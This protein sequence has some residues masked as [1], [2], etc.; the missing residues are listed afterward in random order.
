MS[1]TI[2][3]CFNKKILAANA[4]ILNPYGVDN[5]YDLVNQGKWTLP[6]MIQMSKAVTSDG[7]EDTKTYGFAAHIGAMDAFWKGSDLK[8]LEISNKGD[9]KIAEDQNS[10]RANSLVATL[11]EF[12]RSSAAK[13]TMAYYD[14]SYVFANA[15]NQANPKCVT[16]N[17]GRS[18]FQMSPIVSITDFGFAELAFEFGMLPVPKYDGS[19]LMYKT[20]PGFEYSVCCIPRVA[21][22][23]EDLCTVLECLAI[24]GYNLTS[25][26]YYSQT[27]RKQISDSAEDYAM[28]ETIK[29]S[30]EID[31]GRLFEV[32]RGIAWEAFRR[33]LMGDK[34]SYDEIFDPFEGPLAVEVGVMNATV[35]TM[36]KKYS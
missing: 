20:T 24:E 11:T 22:G 17:A 9:L 13:T 16:W 30:I 6:T 21:I 32:H 14:D 29:N 33:A 25:P 4:E 10:S 35:R 31:T 15:I 5:M 36:E 23:F 28:W 18:L 7:S 8:W 12:Y 26:A 34:S 19:Q 3:M 27:L 2:A 1:E